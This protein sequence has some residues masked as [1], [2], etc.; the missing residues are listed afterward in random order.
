M[1]VAFYETQQDTLATVAWQH[2]PC[3]YYVSFDFYYNY[4]RIDI[5][6][7]VVILYFFR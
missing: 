4:F 7:F 5:F 6:T 3:N 1:A 2:M